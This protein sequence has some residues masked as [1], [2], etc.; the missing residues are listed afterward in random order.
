[1]ALLSWLSFPSP[2]PTRSVRWPVRRDHAGRGRPGGPGRRSAVPGIMDLLPCS[3]MRMW[4]TPEGDAWCTDE[5]DCPKLATLAS[6]TA[7]SPAAA[8]GLDQPD[9]GRTE[10]WLPQL[11]D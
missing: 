10:A 7:S 2:V 5:D 9:T 4:H 8:C 6:S 11:G 1:M 3:A